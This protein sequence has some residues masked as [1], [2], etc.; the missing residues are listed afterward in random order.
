MADDDETNNVV[1][2]YVFWL[3]K[4]NNLHLLDIC[5]KQLTP[6]ASCFLY[7]EFAYH[8]PKKYEILNWMC[9]QYLGSKS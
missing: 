6:G 5:R 3:K 4:V 1:D 8:V 9:F 2:M 7:A